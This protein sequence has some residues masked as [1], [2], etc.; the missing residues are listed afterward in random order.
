MNTATVIGKP[1]IL[2]KHGIGRKNFPNDA[3]ALQQLH[4][5]S[6]MIPNGLPPGLSLPTVK[7]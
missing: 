7:H 1:H 4:R 6:C 3:P 5:K 2:P